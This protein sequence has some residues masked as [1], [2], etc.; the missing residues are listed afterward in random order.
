MSRSKII[1]ILVSVVIFLLCS[2]LPVYISAEEFFD[3]DFDYM[4]DVPEGYKV[5]E[6]TPDGLSY[7]FS[8]D[9]MAVSLVLRLYVD[10]TYSSTKDAVCATLDKFSA[11]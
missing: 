8:H 10:G 3:N 2:L 5:A 4:L 7:R 1:S 9:R 11:Q 6:M